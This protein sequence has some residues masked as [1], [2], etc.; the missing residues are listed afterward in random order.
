MQAQGFKKTMQY[1]KLKKQL[2]TA[3]TR[4][5]DLE[6]KLDKKFDL[7]IS[8]QQ[9]RLETEK[10]ILDALKNM[11][12]PPDTVTPPDSFSEEDYEDFFTVGAPQFASVGAPGSLPVEHAFLKETM[13]FAKEGG[14]SGL[15]KTKYFKESNFQYHP[16]DDSDSLVYLAH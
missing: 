15:V 4:I 2:H 1:G 9:Q 8:I 10:G 6:E 12:S 13:G 7:L 14:A 11:L 5:T 3:N 16:F